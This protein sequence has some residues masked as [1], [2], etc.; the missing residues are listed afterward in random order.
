MTYMYLLLLI[1]WSFM[2][3]SFRIWNRKQD[4][5][6]ERLIEGFTKINLQNKWTFKKYA[7]TK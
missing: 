7:S 2:P 1:N 4:P 3:I 6:L 5:V